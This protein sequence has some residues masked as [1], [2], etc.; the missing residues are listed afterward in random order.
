LCYF[1]SNRFIIEEA[2]NSLFV[3]KEFSVG[4]RRR[5]GALIQWIELQ[6]RKEM[7]RSSG[8]SRQQRISESD[9]DLALWTKGKKKVGKG[10]RQGPK[11]GAK[12]QQSSLLNLRG[13]VLLLVVVCQLIHHPMVGAQTKLKRS[14]RLRVLY[15][16]GHRLSF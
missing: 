16:V 1:K 14:H 4:Q 2:H 11:G 8:S 10:A 6:G 7:R 5:K 9:E 12:P 3:C 15:L 13:S